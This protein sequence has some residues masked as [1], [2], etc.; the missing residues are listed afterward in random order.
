M[1]GE[2]GGVPG[3]SGMHGNAQVLV[4]E[5]VSILPP[6]EERTTW[7]SQLARR[8]RHPKERLREQKTGHGYCHSAF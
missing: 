3:A 8:W 7:F 6:N 5:V 2:N 1:M 4:Y